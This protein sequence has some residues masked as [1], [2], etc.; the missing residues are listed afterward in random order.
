MLDVGLERRRHSRHSVSK[1]KLSIC[2]FGSTTSQ[3]DCLI[4]SEANYLHLNVIMHFNW[5]HHSLHHS[6]DINGCLEQSQLHHHHHHH[7]H[8]HI[9]RGIKTTQSSFPFSL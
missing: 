2:L 7:H 4:F 6:M 9:S 8:Y 5:H 1:M 3:L